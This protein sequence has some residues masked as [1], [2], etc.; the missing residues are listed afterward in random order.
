M[1]AADDADHPDETRSDKTRSDGSGYEGSGDPADGLAGGR[2]DAGA[3]GRAA[4]HAQPGERS[5]TLRARRRRRVTTDPVPGSDPHPQ[6]EE[7][8]HS[9]GEN[10][11]RL[12]G[13]KPPHWG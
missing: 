9:V 7:R 1:A 12:K 6:P 13:D 10:D 2:A 4:A 3:G 8:R 11:E 5:S